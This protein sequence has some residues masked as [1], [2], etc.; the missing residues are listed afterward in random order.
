[1]AIKK[2]INGY[3]FTVICADLISKSNRF[4]VK[5]GKKSEKIK[6]QLKKIKILIN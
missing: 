4:I 2:A 5:L 1:M 6:F 3:V